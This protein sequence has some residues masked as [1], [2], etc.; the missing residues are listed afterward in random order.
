MSW[1]IKLIAE[2]FRVLMD[3]PIEEKKEY[4]D[5]NATYDNPDDYFSAS[6]W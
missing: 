1:L 3:N 6:D 2:F 4:I 5:V